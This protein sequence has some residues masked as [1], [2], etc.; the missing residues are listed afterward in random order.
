MY[1]FAHDYCLSFEKSNSLHWICGNTHMPSRNFDRSVKK[2]KECPKLIL[3]KK[4]AISKGDNLSWEIFFFG[5][6]L[7]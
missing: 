5:K 4:F 2:S 1:F 3:N 7:T 6:T